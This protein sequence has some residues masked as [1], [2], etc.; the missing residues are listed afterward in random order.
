MKV[1]IS[2]CAVVNLDAPVLPAYEAVIDGATFWLVWCRHCAKWH[3]Y[4]AAEGH[5]EAHCKDSQSDY[6]K[7]G[8]NLAYAG[9]WKQ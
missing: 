6:W 9:V 5:R 8:Y 7:T 2:D 4:G 3:C 1:P